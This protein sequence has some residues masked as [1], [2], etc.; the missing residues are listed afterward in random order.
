M[1]DRGATNKLA[2]NDRGAPTPGPAKRCWTSDQAPQLPTGARPWWR[3]GRGPTTIALRVFPRTLGAERR[4]WNAARTR[5]AWCCLTF[6]L[7]PTTEA[8]GVRLG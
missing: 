7:T 1:H 3:I 8:G 5:A 4:T 6:E 2:F